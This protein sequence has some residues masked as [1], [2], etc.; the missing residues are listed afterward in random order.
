VSRK[1]QKSQKG[2]TIAP[3]SLLRRLTSRSFDTMIVEEIIPG[4]TSICPFFFSDST[5]KNPWQPFSYFPAKQDPPL[6]KAPDVRE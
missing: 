1:F 4:A 3:H 2:D 5:F 6:Y